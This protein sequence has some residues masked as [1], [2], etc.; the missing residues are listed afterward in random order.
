MRNFKIIGITGPTGSG[1]S[2]ITAYLKS[3]GY[4]VIDADSLGRQALQ[5]GSDCLVQA[6][7]AFGDDILN[8]DGTLNRPLLAKRAFSTPENTARLNSITHPWIC[9]QVVE[10]VDSI[11]KSDSNPVI[12]FD[13]AVL[14]ESKM[15]ILCDYV[16]AVVA[17]LEIRKQRIMT[18]D[19]L[20]EENADIRINAQNKD[21]FYISRSDFV[22]D[23]S[24]SLEEIYVK[25]DEMLDSVIGG[26]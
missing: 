6:C 4:Y 3:K 11:R 12:L 7:I 1:K 2:T 14:L 16:L 13:A 21:E 22:I 17:P 23:G 24:L 20:T 25:A 15:D 19:N 5:K 18:R 10:I 8:T 9:M 26:E